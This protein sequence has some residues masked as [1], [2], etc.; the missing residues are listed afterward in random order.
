MIEKYRILP[1]NFGMAVFALRAQRL[2]VYIIFN[3]AG[4][5]ACLKWNVKNRFDVAV[6]TDHFFVCTVECVVSLQVM[7]EGGF[8]P[9]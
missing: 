1:G 3:V 8:G 4:L 9:V 5:T 7:D 6:I 2:L